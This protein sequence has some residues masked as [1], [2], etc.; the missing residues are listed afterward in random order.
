M[1]D[2]KQKITALGIICIALSALNEFISKPGSEKRIDSYPNMMFWYDMED[3]FVE[4]Y[5]VGEF[6]MRFSYRHESQGLPVQ[7]GES[8]H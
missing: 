8:K 2:D 7:E 5:G 1:L 3:M 6:A 4:K